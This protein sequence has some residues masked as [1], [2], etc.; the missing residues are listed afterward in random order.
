MFGLFGKS[1]PRIATREALEDFLDANAA[2]LVQRCLYEYA[3]G[4]AAY[5]WQP[6][7]EEPIFRAA[8]ERSRWRAYPLGLAAVA[9]V[10]EGVLRPAAARPDVLMQAM[11]RS[12]ARVL[13]RHQPPAEIG[14][15]EW[16][17]AG[18]DVQ[19]RVARAGLA[20][21][22][23]VR[24]VAAGIAPEVF[25]L[26]PIVEQFRGKD[27]YMARN[28]LSVALIAIHDEFVERADTAAL[29]AALAGAG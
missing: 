22:R 16:A 26:I 7:M 8:M 4:A 1:R 14:E 21:P 5:Q 20:A 13:A 27:P 24:M 9:E 2:Y 11:E 12:C 28:N 10:A 15:A 17:E 29:A 6:L 19:S 18:A 25:E 3:R 23:P